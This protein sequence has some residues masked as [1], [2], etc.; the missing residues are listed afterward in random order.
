LAR[1]GIRTGALADR[2]EEEAAWMPP[3]EGAGGFEELS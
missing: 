3:T 1:E 2:R